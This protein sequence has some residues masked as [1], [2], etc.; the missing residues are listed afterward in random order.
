[1]AQN[2]HPWG[3][4]LAKGQGV[5]AT[6]NLWGNY[7]YFSAYFAAFSGLCGTARVLLPLGTVPQGAAE[8]TQG[9]RETHME[10]HPPHVRPHPHCPPRS[11]GAQ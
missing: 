6:S 4:G 2:R 10:Q 9:G 7:D 11:P 1:M 3:R 5:N 8:G